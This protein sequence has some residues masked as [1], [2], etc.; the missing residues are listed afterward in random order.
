MGI[1]K[2]LMQGKELK[3]LVSWVLQN[4]QHQEQTS[5]FTLLAES[6]YKHVIIVILYNKY[7]FW[8]RSYSYMK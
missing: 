3:R 8:N 7:P 4:D 1:I 6:M 2:Y 5:A